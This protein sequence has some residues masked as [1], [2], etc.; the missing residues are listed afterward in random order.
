M[1]FELCERLASKEP[2]F[3]PI[4]AHVDE[5][6][7]SA[8]GAMITAFQLV[9]LKGLKQSQCESALNLLEDAGLLAR[10]EMHI[11]PTEGCYTLN[12][13]FETACS[14]CGSP[15][16]T[17][18][19]TISVFT[20][21]KLY[22]QKLPA[23]AKG[24]NL[25]LFIHGLGGD[26]IGTWEQFP[27]LLH[28]SAQIKSDYDYAHYSYPT[29]WGRTLKFWKKSNPRIEILADALKT[30]IENRH[31]SYANV[32]FICHSLGGLIARKH[33]ANEVR[34]HGRCTKVK[35]ILLFATPNKGSDLANLAGIIDWRLPQIKQLCKNS[36]FINTLNREWA[37]LKIEEKVRVKYVLGGQ[38]NVVDEN[39]ARSH[40]TANFETIAS[41]EHVS[42]VK[43]KSIDD[44]AFIIA[45]RFLI[46]H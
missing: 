36:E 26:P 18:C 8:S 11:C 41:G 29:D 39:S 5:I 7:S 25:I 44:S 12:S 38:D 45:H 1:F 31:H 3:A 15:I 19:G 43:P 6:L 14:S 30:E 21:T 35:G 4:I 2:A 32:V 33:I 34:K 27:D 42:I 22:A 46:E 20:L 23:R 24:K 28:Q 17:T 37:E 9:E 40:W 10:N 16:D 13:P